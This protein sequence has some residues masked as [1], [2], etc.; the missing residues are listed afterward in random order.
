M[1]ILMKQ[2]IWKI[3]LS[4]K[5]QRI[6]QFKLNVYV[7]KSSPTSSIGLNKKSELTKSL[8]AERHLCQTP[9]ILCQQLWQRTHLW[10]IHILFKLF[11]CTEKLDYMFGFCIVKYAQKILDRRRRIIV[12]NI[13][14]SQFCGKQNIFI[15]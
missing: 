13:R 8:H 5:F 14:T 12:D 2:I 10:N 7:I 11:S 3:L 4:L 15:F 9:F 6:I 1:K